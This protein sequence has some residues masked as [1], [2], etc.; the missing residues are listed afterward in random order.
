MPPGLVWTGIYNPPLPCPALPSLPFL[1]APLPPLSYKEFSLLSLSCSDYLS[2]PSV[3]LA[4]KNRMQVGTGAGRERA[5]AEQ[6]WGICCRRVFP[7][8]PA[9]LSSSLFCSGFGLIWAR[10]Y[11]PH[12]HAYTAHML[13]L[14]LC[15]LL[16]NCRRRVWC[17]RCPPSE[18]T[19]LMTTSPTSSAAARAARAA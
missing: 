10:I 8:P 4:I 13:M 19:A 18:W 2:L 15:R 14:C 12:T 16:N 5:V 6:G 1:P 9:P 3:G 7:W 11:T 17:C